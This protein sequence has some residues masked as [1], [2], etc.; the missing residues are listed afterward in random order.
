MGMVGGAWIEFNIYYKFFV[1]N[2][3]NKNMGNYCQELLTIYPR[4]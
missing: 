3:D 1:V 2:F 4:I